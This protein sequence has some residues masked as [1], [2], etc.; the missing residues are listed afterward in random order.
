MTQFREKQA[1]LPDHNVSIV[2]PV[3]NR[4]DLLT[5]TIDS[6]LAQTYQDWLLTVVDDGSQNDVSAL[7]GR[8]D[9]SRINL[10]RQKNQGN[11]SAR[12]T[13]IA[14]SH[15]EFI[16]CIDSDDVWHPDFLRLCLEHLIGNQNIDVV[17]TQVQPID[18]IGK[19]LP[20]IIDSTPHRGNL[21]EPL[22][23]G[24]PLLPS[25]TMVRRSCFERWGSY[26]E[27]FDDWEMWLR[28][29]ANGCE[30]DCIEK[31]LVYY[32]IHSQNLNQDFDQRLELHF[33][34]LD[35]FY[36]SGD[37]PDTA[38]RLREEAYA[39][40]HFYFCVLAW[41][42]GRKDQALIQFSQA[43]SE[44]PS[45]LS[46]VDFYTRIACAHQGRLN[47]GSPQGL[48]LDRA[49]MSLHHSLDYLFKTGSPSHNNVKEKG[50]AYGWAFFSLG[51]LAYGVALDN[52]SA[53]SF[54]LKA[55]KSWPAFLWRTDWIVWWIR[56][57]LGH[58][59]VQALKSKNFP[60]SSHA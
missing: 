23:L 20:N 50:H 14:R 8:Y 33:S 56:S 19:L 12:N 58:G 7:L 18:E 6:I 45:Y 27:G 39:K 17:Y 10:I 44:N 53:R 1:H 46:D 37:L 16:A 47:A 22:L 15:G 34:M 57:I 25:A 24:F 29:A 36:S 11:A 2:I 26:S 43:I 28:W 60:R 13:G 5:I 30:F 32:R 4:L 35:K 38:Y 31:P 41:Q 52:K 55:L 42:L 40:Q 48:N 54:F 9:D 49:V 3:Y 59:T 21:L 51:R